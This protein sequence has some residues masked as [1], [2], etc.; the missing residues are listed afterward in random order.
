[1][2]IVEKELGADCAGTSKVILLLANRNDGEHNVP[3]EVRVH[4]QLVFARTVCKVLDAAL[5]LACCP[6]VQICIIH[7]SEQALKNDRE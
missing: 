4:M 6:G 2:G 7:L 5:V 1:V 3:K